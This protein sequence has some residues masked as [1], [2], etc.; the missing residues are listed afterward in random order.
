[1]P[2]NLVENKKQLLIFLINCLK[3]S[4]AAH[5]VDVG[6]RLPTPG[7]NQKENIL[8]IVVRTKTTSITT[9]KEYEYVL[10]HTFSANDE[11]DQKKPCMRINS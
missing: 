2:E 9:S 10:V 8:P 4:L 7:L 11:N 6:R 1:M 5:K 3:P